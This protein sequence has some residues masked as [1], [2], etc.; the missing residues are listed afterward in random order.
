MYKIGENWYKVEPFPVESFAPQILQPM[1]NHTWKYTNPATLATSGIYSQSDLEK[2]RDHIMFPAEKPMVLN[3]LGRGFS[4]YDI[5]NKKMTIMNLMDEETLDKIASSAWGKFWTAFTSF[6][7][8]SAGLIGIIIIIRIIKLIADT[9][10][11]CYALHRVFGWSFKLLGAFWDSVTN[12]L[13]HIGRKE[14]SSVDSKI[15]DIEIGQ[16]KYP[17]P[18]PENLNP[19]KT[20]R[21]NWENP[22]IQ[23][24]YPNPNIDNNYVVHV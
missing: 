16:L 2:L 17:P 12:L 22:N 5:S 18:S 1:K 4:G 10:I 3:T 11:H 6:G 21:G 24:L 20:I 23:N 13:L 15:Q 7:T 14:T 8:A 9:Y 19:D